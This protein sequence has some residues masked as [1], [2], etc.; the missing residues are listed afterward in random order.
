MLPFQTQR[1]L[2]L[3]YRSVK[4]EQNHVHHNSSGS[5]SIQVLLEI[6]KPQTL[7]NICEYLITFELKGY[8]NVSVGLISLIQM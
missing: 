5:E 6:R 2:L 3:C 7:M 8:F 1:C 4:Q